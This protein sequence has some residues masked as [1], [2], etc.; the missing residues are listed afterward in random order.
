MKRDYYEVL[1]VAKGAS[2]G[3][4][5]KAYRKL[6][7]EWH[8]DRNKSSEAE[9]KF[10]K[11]NEAYEILS[12]AKKKQ[13]YDQFGHAAFAPGAGPFGAGARTYARR[14]GPFTYTYTTTR[15]GSPFANFDFS[16][17]WLPSCCSISAI[18][19]SCRSDFCLYWFKSWF[20]PAALFWEVVM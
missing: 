13:A 10:K 1:G 8:P 18:R 6:A 20:N 9:E 12:D 11:I 2:E 4:I 17:T 16:F 3:E 7:L 14:Q 5:K 19:A 15:G